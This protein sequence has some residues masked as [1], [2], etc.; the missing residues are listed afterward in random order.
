MSDTSPGGTIESRLPWHNHGVTIRAIGHDDLDTLVEYRN[1]EEV[2]VLQD[3]EVPYERSRAERLVPPD[4]G[5][6][7]VGEWAQVAI[8]FDGLFVGDIG[9]HVPEPGGVAWIGYSV[10]PRHWGRGI[11]TH[12]VS[13]VVRNLV[14]MGASIVKASVDPRNEASIAL[15]V[16]CGFTLL[17]EKAPIVVRGDE[18][19]DDVYAW[20]PGF[21]AVGTDGS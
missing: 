17:D 20:E 8:E 14:E 10:H 2:W 9:F 15:L 1:M 13:L 6:L 21:D 18:Y 3:W 12:A 4:S 7:A 16:R 19:L 5:L 11:A